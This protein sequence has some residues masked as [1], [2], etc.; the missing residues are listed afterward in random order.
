M[1]TTVQLRAAH[2]KEIA[3]F[4]KVILDNEEGLHV[5]PRNTLLLLR[6]KLQDLKR[7]D[8]QTMAKNST[9]LH[10]NRTVSDCLS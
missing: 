8:R 6:P 1:R 10:G 5:F 4:G 7:K 9:K 3:L 2:N